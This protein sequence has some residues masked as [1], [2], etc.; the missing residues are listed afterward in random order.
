MR[1]FGTIYEG[2]LESELSEAETDLTLDKGGAYVPVKGKQ[3]AVVRAGEVYL[4][5]RSGARKASGSYFTKSFAVEH[6]LDGAL[7]P[8]LT[9]HLARL[10]GLGEADAAEG[11]FH[12][13]VADIAMGSGHFLVAA[14]DR[15][16][17]Q[18]RNVWVVVLCR[19]SV[20]SL[21]ISAPRR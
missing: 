12:F 21:P 13:R 3:I 18:L 9:D 7:E 20:K 17:G 16:E 1:E 5:D 15:I 2:L 8:A 6:L 19:A 10:D 11:F 4:H 14:I